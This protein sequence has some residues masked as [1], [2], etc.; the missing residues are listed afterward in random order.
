MFLGRSERGSE[1]RIGFGEAAGDRLSDGMGLDARSS[2][3]AAERGA[4][5]A[6]LEGAFEP[7]PCFN[8]LGGP[9]SWSFAQGR[10]GV[11][12]LRQVGLRCGILT[13]HEFVRRLA[14][15]TLSPVAD[16]VDGQ[17]LDQR[18]KRV[19]GR[20]QWFERL[21]A[22]R[23]GV[24]MSASGTDRRSI[25]GG[26]F[27]AGAA[28]AAVPL[29]PSPTR[30]AVPEY[31]KLRDILARGHLVV[32]TGTD[33]PPYYFQSDTGELSG[34]EIE[35][36]RLIATGLFEDASKVE[37]A[38]QTSD[39][40][41][42]NLL[43][44]RVDVTIQNL[45]VTAGRAQQIDFTVPYYRSAQGFLL[46]ASGRF[47][48]FDEIKKAGADVT[49]SAIQNVFIANWI[50][51]ALPNARVDQ[52]AT[53]DAAL[54][55]LNAGRADAHYIDQ[56]RIDWTLQQLPGRYLDSGFSHK[57]GS[58]AC[59]V[60]PGEARWLSVLNTSLREAMNGVD[61]SVYAAIFKR[62]LGQEVPAPKPG[63]P[64]EFIA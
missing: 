8:D 11:L 36:A 17:S 9:L 40:R 45:T 43:S 19:T 13:K 25:L 21:H 57:A 29:C 42:P 32:G 37:F 55:A 26:V 3:E 60:K 22:I 27:V 53:P 50:H 41:I 20:G 54:Q 24:G 64:R 4:A 63:Y 12:C 28:L 48:S 1:K 7:M 35:L 62:W 51:E 2:P 47:K 31:G 61:H 44:D 18:H 56:G 30:A 46:R 49:I 6:G 5:G 39:A 52:F 14:P 59:G 23:A 16:E 10:D 38:S 15:P 33:I 58:V 34:L